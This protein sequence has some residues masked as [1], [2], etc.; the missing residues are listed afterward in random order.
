MKTFRARCTVEPAKV[1]EEFLAYA[2]SN[3]VKARDYRLIA[4]DLCNAAKTLAAGGDEKDTETATGMV[5]DAVDIV[6]AGKEAFKEEEGWDKLVQNV[7]DTA[8]KLGIDDPKM[9]AA[10]SS[11]GYAGE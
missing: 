10:L 1:K 11:L 9:S 6:T 2:G 3:E 4:V 8:G 5:F 7:G